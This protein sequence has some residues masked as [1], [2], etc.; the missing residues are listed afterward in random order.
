MCFCSVCVNLSV[1]CH[2]V[3]ELSLFLNVDYDGAGIE[4]F[5]SCLHEQHYPQLTCF[6]MHSHDSSL[7]AI[8]PTNNCH[9]NA[10]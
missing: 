6:F 2:Q 10:G 3:K 7:C 8:D 5:A 4:T 9:A 1:T